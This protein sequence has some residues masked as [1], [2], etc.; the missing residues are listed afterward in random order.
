MGGGSRIKKIRP[1]P[2]SN[3]RPPRQTCTPTHADAR[4]DTISTRTRANDTRTY[5]CALHQHDALVAE[6]V[7]CRVPLK[8]PPN[9]PKTTTTHTKKNQVQTGTCEKVDPPLG[10]L[11]WHIR[12]VHTRARR[13]ASIARAGA[14]SSWSGDAIQNVRTVSSDSWLVRRGRSAPAHTV[15]MKLPFLTRSSTFFRGTDPRLGWSFG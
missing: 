3:A 10:A 9:S 1:P 8:R 2:P 12:R 6:R 4:I 7:R 5:S 13:A 11:A 14:L 15:C